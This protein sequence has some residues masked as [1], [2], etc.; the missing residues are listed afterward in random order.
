MNISL[1]IIAVSAILVL[2]LILKFLARD[3]I[4]SGDDAVYGPTGTDDLPADNLFDFSK[5]KNL[6]SSAKNQVYMSKEERF[7]IKLINEIKK[8]LKEKGDKNIYHDLTGNFI[9]S[10]WR[11]MINKD[12]LIRIYNEYSKPNAIIHYI[13]IYIHVKEAYKKKL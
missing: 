9:L 11:T 10:N 5:A 7:A 3:N 2:M 6:M 4:N 13:S 8:I 1:I 12:K